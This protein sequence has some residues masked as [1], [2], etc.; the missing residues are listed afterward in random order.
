[1]IKLPNNQFDSEGLMCPSCGCNNL[2][3][4]GVTLFNRSEDEREKFESGERKPS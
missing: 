3:H 4:S 2:H 1:M